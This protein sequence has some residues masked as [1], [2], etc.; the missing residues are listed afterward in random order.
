MSLSNLVFL[1]ALLSFLTACST[2]KNSATTQEEVYWV[3][4]E[5]APCSAGAGKQQCLQVYKGEDLKNANWEYFYA[6]IEGFEFEEGYLKKI[7]VTAE[8]LEAEE[9][10]ADAS[11][12]RYTLVEELEK[13]VD[14]TSA[15]AGNW[16]LA[17]I[18][19]QPINRMV[20]LPTLTLDRT[21]MQVSGSGN[22]YSG[23]IKRLTP[24]SI[25]L[26][27]LLLTRKACANKNI[28]ADYA[29]AME[30]IE[31]YTIEDEQLIFYDKEGARILSFIQ[32]QATPRGEKS[33]P[34]DYQESL[35]GNWINTTIQDI[36][37]NRS[38]ATPQLELN[39]NQER[40]IGNNGCN[41]YMGAIAEVNQKTLRFGRISAT[42][43]LCP[44]MD[45]PNRFTKAL[46]T[47]VAYQLE[48]SN[49]TLLDKAG[50]E[51]LTF[52]RGE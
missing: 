34:T 14:Y 25:D 39:L 35:H 32:T 23:T 17:T 10:P 50:K 16:T 45:V 22:N 24:T 2:P 40:I 44:D 8:E 4:G 51:V 37:T 7:I 15:T 1:A 36:P 42:K 29:Q 11:S 3:S 52:S 27:P 31:T 38:S 26:S 9:V 13:Q 47:I 21:N 49:L 41:D 33:N 18:N 48:G 30:Q 28:E 20:P 46:N 19:N 43:K 5:K 6:P 12:I